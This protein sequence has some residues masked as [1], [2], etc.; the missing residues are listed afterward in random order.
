MN[1]KRKVIA[2]RSSL[3]MEQAFFGT[4]A[5]KLK[6][7]DDPKAKKMW[8]DGISLGF[9]PTWAE[10]AAHDEL[11]ARIC[12][13]TMHNANGHAWRRDQRD[14]KE[15]NE[16]ADFALW[17]ILKEAGFALPN[18][19]HYEE[20]FTGM[21]VERIY[22]LRHDESKRREGDRPSKDPPPPG[23]DKGPKRKRPKEGNGPTRPA[24]P[25]DQP[26]PDQEPSQDP[27]SDGEVRDPPRPEEKAALD[28]DWRISVLQA[29][30]AAKARGQLPAGLEQL[31]EEIRNPQIDWPAAMRKWMQSRSK[32]DYSWRVLN[33]RYAAQ[34]LLLPGLHSEA[35]GAM[36]IYWDTSGSRDT[37]KARAECAAEAVEI[38]YEV[39][40]EKLYIIYADSVVHRVD[41]FER[42]DMVEFRPIGGG[43]TAFEPVFE[44]IAD[45]EIAIDCLI[46]IT[47]LE[48]SFPTE[49]PDYPVLWAATTS[50]TPPFGD[51]LRIHSLKD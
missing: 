22:S 36:A 2:A 47:D 33:R 19:V 12:E 30:Q 35:M 28:G 39:Q 40:P 32:D 27:G 11:K 50:H 5:M 31:L 45:H 3:I 29:A 6:L 51:V 38:F 23:G 25:D 7:V 26:D 24:G 44:Y 1:G 20:R 37:A 41:E 15:W 10:S 4:L 49:A 18:D 42:G 34:G 8:T 9:N 43:G 46:G 21:A 14:P 16:A 17:A 13:I 48:G